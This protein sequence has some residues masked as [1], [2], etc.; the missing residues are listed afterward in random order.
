MLE[1]KNPTQTPANNR[2]KWREVCGAAVN[3][4]DLGIKVRIRQ[5]V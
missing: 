3:L 5:P 2:D 1:I 4:N